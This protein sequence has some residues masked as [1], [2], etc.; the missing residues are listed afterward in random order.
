MDDQWSYILDNDFARKFLQTNQS[1]I[2][3]QQPAFSPL[4]TDCT[5]I[6]SRDFRRNVTPSHLRKAADSC[7][8]CGTL[9]KCLDLEKSSPEDEKESKLF[10]RGSILMREDDEH[11]VLRIY[12]WA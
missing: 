12:I 8:L 1:D 4:C 10:R 3:P 7:C 5:N 9:W 2:L 6:S 11:P